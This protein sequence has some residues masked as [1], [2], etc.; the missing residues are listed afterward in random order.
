M[1]SDQEMC[2]RIAAVRRKAK[3]DTQYVQDVAAR[4]N[5]AV[6]VCQRHQFTAAAEGLLQAA[7]RMVGIE[8]GE[9]E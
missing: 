3:M 1:M 8:L 9:K 4:Y 5:N 2:K 6:R 7:E